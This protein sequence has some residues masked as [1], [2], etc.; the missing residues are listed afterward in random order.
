MKRLLTL[1]FVMLCFHGFTQMK[2]SKQPNIIWITCEDISPYIGAYGA[3]QV[4]TPN[5]DQLA[6]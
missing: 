5:I 4:R 2:K 6:Q 3:S 1:L